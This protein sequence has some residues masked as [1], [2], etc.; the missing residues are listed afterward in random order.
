MWPGQIFLT[1][2]H[3]W[4]MILPVSPAM[5]RRSIRGRPGSLGRLQPFWGLARRNASRS[6]R[7]CAIRP[8]FSV[9]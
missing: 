6:R 8:L 7:N 2:G 1:H 4:R 3:A 9:Q 5:C